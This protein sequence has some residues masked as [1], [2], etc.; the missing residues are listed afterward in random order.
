M[1]YVLDTNACIRILKGDSPSMLRSI[2]NISS[3]KIIVPSIVCFELYYGAYKSSRSED[4]LTKLNHFLAAFEYADLNDQICRIAG[5]L[6]ADLERKGLPVGPYDLLIGAIA[7]S[8]NS[9]LITHNVKEFSRMDNL[10]IEDWE[11]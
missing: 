7:I 5:K 10:M 1:K 8:L 3:E 6:R 11:A 4:T 2:A 9:V